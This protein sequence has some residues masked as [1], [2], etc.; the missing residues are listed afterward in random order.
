MEM[1]S[2]E[3]PSSAGRHRPGLRRLS[4]DQIGKASD[5]TAAQVSRIGLT[6]VGTVAFCLLSLLSPDSAL[7]GSSEKLAKHI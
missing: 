4:A 2:T 6:F 3:Q 7:L 5:D 1:A